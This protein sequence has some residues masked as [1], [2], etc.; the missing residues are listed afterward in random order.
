MSTVKPLRVVIVG[1]AGRMGKEALRALNDSPEMEIVGAVVRSQA[2]V[3]AREIAGTS[4]VDLLLEADLGSVLE[5]TKPD[6]VVDLSH[7]SV[8][9]TNARL[10]TSVGASLV[11]GCTGLGEA[12][13]R[14][15]AECVS[16]AGVGAIYAPNFAIG[17]VLMMRFAETA[18]KWIPDVEIIEMHHDRKEDAPSGTAL[19]TADLVIAARTSEPTEMPKTLFKLEGARGGEREGV[20]IHSVRLPGLLAHQQVI[21]GAPGEVLTIRHDAMDRSVYMGGLKLC[22]QKVSA[23][24]G[25]VVGLDKILF[26]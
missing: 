23:L 15:I 9:V 17:A 14:E 5:R 1:A 10:A 4:A 2:G 12:E 21:F 7:S 20:H 3:N 13:I 16:A 11:V 8:A 24:P 25:L 26:G 22:V 19:H 6:V 18:A